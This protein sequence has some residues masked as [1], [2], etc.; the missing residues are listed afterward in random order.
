MKI[1]IITTL[2]PGF[3]FSFCYAQTPNSVRLN[4]LFK[5]LDL[6]HQFM[7]SMAI[8]KNDTIVY[9]KT[10]GLADVSTNK[11]ATNETK[12]RIGSISKM[13]T[14]ALIFKAVEEKKMNLSQTIDL[15]FPAI[16]NAKKITVGNL[17]NHR[18]GLH[19][20]TNDSI[21]LKYYTRPQTQ[22]EMLDIFKKSKSDFE[23]NSKSEYSNTNYVLL[24]F[25]LE[26]IYKKTFSTLLLEKIVNPLEL[27]NTY[28][29]GKISDNEAHSYTYNNKW[30]KETET[31]MSIP[32]GAGAIIS[33][34]TDLIKFIES[35]F[36]GK[37]ISNASL[38]KM[39]TLQDNYGM[40]IFKVPYNEKIGYGHTGGIDAFRS[41]LYYFPEEKVAIAITAN[42]QSYTNN[43][44][45]IAGLSWYFNRP[46]T[47]PSFKT[48]VYKT[49]DLDQYLGEYSSTEIA[50]KIT[51]T[52][53]GNNLFAQA[54]GQSAFPL[55]SF[56]KDK[57]EFK[58]AGI[59]MEFDT[60][61]KQMIL[62]QGG[63]KYNFIKK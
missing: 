35:L 45:V 51:V 22:R 43:D 38:E 21:Y 5:S 15:Y 7:G 17:L 55:Q 42:G 37:I 47:I 12:Y 27:K 61:K 48:T 11:K 39:K 59:V 25:M 2:I 53:E 10:I 14:S 50:L 3:I 41:V 57:F 1:F 34:P 58:Q 24:S 4:S 44:L 30:D 9:S 8:S 54:T 18:S 40:G 56:E 33:T 6:N 23:P 36:A 16:E 32:M 62:K 52:K 13:F 46:F 31:D 49:E 20:F 26:K 29:G 60:D 63:G 19:N 28:V